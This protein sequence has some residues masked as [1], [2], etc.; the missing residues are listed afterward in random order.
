MDSSAQGICLIVGCGYVGHPLAQG[1][2]RKGWRVGA[3]VKS[4]SSREKLSGQGFEV[5]QGDVADCSFWDDL[6]SE[7]GH[8]VYCPSTGGGGVS[9]YREI[10]E[11][12]LKHCLEWLPDG[13][14]LFYT[15]STSV[16]GQEDGELVDE[17]SIT[18]P[19]SESAQELVHA[20]QRVCTAGQT[21][22]RLGGIYGPERGV[23]LKRL[24]E[25]KALIPEQDP[26]WL[27]LVYLSDIVSAITYGLS[28]RLVSGEV[29]N[30]IDNQP[31]SYREIYQWLCERLEMMVPPIGTPDY[32]GKRGM[33]N[34]RVSNQKL[35]NTGWQPEY[36]SFR[37][38]R[39]C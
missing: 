4:D 19:R 11:L 7:W 28:G 17:S 29:Y 14:R 3:V 24:R 22:L 13:S 10:H 6:H 30:V 36:S 1:L 33:S 38:I 20:E 15:S 39:R 8:V 31:S 32:F 5:L 12:G 23:L 18:T 37:A 26:K 16:Y 35:R 34:K 21:V 9:A 2:S 25:G 27:N